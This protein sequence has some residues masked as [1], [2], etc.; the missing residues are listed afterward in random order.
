MRHVNE[1]N[2]ET[3]H[4]TAPTPDLQLPAPEAFFTKKVAPL[5]KRCVEDLKW[6]LISL[7]Q[8]I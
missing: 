4:N 2:I 5:T 6:Q 8:Q 7:G 1:E 3:E